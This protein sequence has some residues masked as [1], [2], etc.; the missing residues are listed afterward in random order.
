M[1][2]FFTLSTGDSIEQTDSFE[3][4]GT[5]PIIPEGTQLHAS[6]L[7]SSWEPETNFNKEHIKIVWY[8]TE[9][10]KYNGFLINQKVKVF[11][12]SSKTSDKAK[13]MLMAIDTN[14]KGELN[15]LANLGKFEPGNN[16]QLSRALNGSNSLITVAVYSMDRDDGTKNEG[17]WV[18]G[19]APVSK[20]Q[21][22]EDKQV[23][24]QAQQK[25]PEPAMANYDYEDSIPF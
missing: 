20:A 15:K 14:A 25:A 2:N 4:S 1:T 24:R 16:T 7:E 21:R 12:E 10:G 6:V 23:E 19:V 13:T 9:K 18:R 17:N 3:N 8:I 22:Q 5:Q 11:D